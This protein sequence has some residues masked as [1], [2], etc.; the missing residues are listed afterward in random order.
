MRRRRRSHRASAI[1]VGR[2]RNVAIADNSAAHGK[3]AKTAVAVDAT[4]DKPTTHAGNNR[5]T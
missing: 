3:I 2:C 1:Y 5:L 4:C